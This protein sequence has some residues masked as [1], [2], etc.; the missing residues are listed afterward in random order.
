MRH[1]ILTITLACVVGMTTYAAGES[2]PPTS[3]DVSKATEKFVKPAPQFTLNDINGSELSLDSLK[4]KYI[5]LD[6]WVSWCKF[7]TASIP[8]MKE[9]YDKY[10]DKMEILAIN[11][12]DTDELWAEIVRQ[13]DV[14]WLNGTSSQSTN[15]LRDYEI[16]KYP[17]KVIISPQGNIVKT[18][19]GEDVRFY[20]YLDKIL[21]K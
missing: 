13:N 8:Q 12:R 15:I 7:C 4:G 3:V 20:K 14:P 16:R 1:L 19:I 17:T 6:F 5:V 18:F 10:K 2:K 11:C 21:G 9:Y